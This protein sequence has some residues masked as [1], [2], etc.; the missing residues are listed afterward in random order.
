MPAR[1]SSQSK[2]PFDLTRFLSRPWVPIV[3]FAL[4]TTGYFYHFLITGDVIYGSDTGA[5]FH[6]GNEPFV[7]AMGKLSPKN[8]SRFMGGTPESSALRSQYYPLVIIDLFTS[9][10]RYF[11]W[12]Y[13][14]AIFTAG[15][16]MFLCARSFGLHPLAA[17]IAGAAYASAPAF[18]S[19]SQAGHYAKMTVIGLFPLMY[20]A[21]NRGM[22]TRRII[23]FL[24]LGGTVGI[25]I[26]SPH[27]QMAYFALWALG[28]LFLYRL[29]WDLFRTRNTKIALYQT[30]LSAG[31]ISLGLAIGAEGV[32]PQY[33]NTTTSSK[34]AVTEQNDG[35]EFAS[36]WSLHPEEIFA[37]VIPEFVSFDTN[38]TTHKYWGRNAFKINSEYVGIVPLFFAILALAHIRKKTHIAFL[39]GLFILAIAYA[40]GPHT[41]LHKLFFYIV[42]GVN[43]L[44]A[45][46]MISFLF[47]FAL[48]ALGAYGLHRLI[49]DDITPEASK[50]LGIAGGICTAILLLFAFAPSI[51][52]SLWQNIVW[53]DIPAPRLQI[54]QTN[55]PLAG[56]GALLAALFVGTLTVISYLRAQNKLQIHTFAL[57]L[58]TVILIDTWR[59]DKM[60][61]NYVN[62]NRV[63]PRE[64]V[65]AD[66]VAFLKRDDSLFRVL[67]LPDRDQMPLPGI[68][69]VRGFHDFAIRRYDTIL[70]SEAI[71]NPAILNL[72]NT[73][74]IITPSERNIPPYLQKIAGRQG[75]HIYRN[76]G[77]LPWFY[78]APQYEIIPDENQILQKLTDPNTHPTQTALLEE[79]PGITSDTGETGSVE[80]LEYNEHQGYLKLQTTAIGPRILVISQNHHPNWR[81]TVNGEPKPLI[82]VNYL[83]TA[84][85]LEPGEHIVELT[86][87]DPIVA[88]T[89]WITLGG[90]IILIAAIALCIY[91]SHEKTD[92]TN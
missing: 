10:Q 2:R 14:F 66:A 54:A 78:L 50:K 52:L 18:L 75:L 26:Y 24:I 72:L 37:L 85:A 58:L 62:P 46:G 91:K 8:W 56:R 6:K 5:E 34:R 83:W 76:P 64:R 12:R 31:A 28:L 40:L 44:R 74:Y 33:W 45:P 16:F 27:L 7:E 39:L 63:P 84:I 3:F 17:L 21:L 86:Y 22:D 61:L 38:T 13:I 81:A 55:L 68:D 92:N 88:T 15:Y 32:I 71:N 47:A 11:G 70:K 42:P 48:C 77:A 19:F 53:T 89:R 43:V 23:Y 20:W 1:R 35:Y 67:A 25:A 36:S 87:R 69:L 49:T 4:L 41:P 30:L 90:V 80:R 51:L 9:E 60:F 82:R 73:K 59:I 57:V 79:D 65:N 29:L